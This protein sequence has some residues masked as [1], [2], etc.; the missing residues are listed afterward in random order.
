MAVV[1]LEMNLDEAEEILKLFP[2]GLVK[3]SALWK[4]KREMKRGLEAGRD[5]LAREQE[6]MRRIRRN[7]RVPGFDETPLT[8][9]SM[10]RPDQRP[11]SAA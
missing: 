1:R 5:S 2:T 6:N 9:H 11:P 10:G 3:G 4:G 8:P 7:R